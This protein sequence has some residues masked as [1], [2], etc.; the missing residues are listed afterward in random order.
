M[1]LGTRGSKWPDLI[2]L[3]LA[4][5]VADVAR[6]DSCVAVFFRGFGADVGNSG[7]DQLEAHLS[8]AFGDDP[9]APFSSAVF[10]WT[11]QAQAL[12]FIQSFDEIDCLVVA[13]HSFGANA[14]VEL[15]A[16]SL[17]P[18]GIP[19]DLLFQFDSVG[20]NDDVLPA[21]VAA[22][23]NYHQVS[24]GGFFEPEGEANVVG[25]TNV[26]V[27]QEYGVADSEIT[28]TEI[29]CPLFERTS[30]E[31]AALFESQPDLYARVEEQVRGL[32]S[33]PAVPGLGLGGLL[34]LLLSIFAGVRLT[35]GP[36]FR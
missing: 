3:V 8:E 20:A 23:F 34:A 24:T 26:Y 15:A 30:E 32:R 31:Y 36:G 18:N 7:M 22:G 6:A 17:I 13:G 28:H 21:G 5:T 10:N 25:S 33:P 29:D 14:A 27:E 19:V 12:G 16:D 9:A 4:L 1:N 2:L 35:R 11:D